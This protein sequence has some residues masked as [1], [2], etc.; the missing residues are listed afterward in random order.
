[1]VTLTR[2]L[3]KQIG[4]I[5]GL[6]YVYER[7]RERTWKCEYREFFKDFCARGAEEMGIVGLRSFIFDG[8][9][10]SMFACCHL[11]MIQ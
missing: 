10:N 9:N 11:R 4:R 5:K 6:E 3:T 7:I 1:M 2:T 8:R